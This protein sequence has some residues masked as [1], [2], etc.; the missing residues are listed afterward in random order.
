[1]QIPTRTETIAQAR[2]RGDRI[3]GVLPIH[4]PRAL[5][6]AHGVQPVEIW[7]PPRQDPPRATRSSRPTRARVVRHGAALL[8]AGPG[9]DVDLILVPPHVRAR[10]RGWVPCCSTS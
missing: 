1:M 5:L 2:Q 4:Y 8:L 7:A 3:A 9:R 6:R 10:C